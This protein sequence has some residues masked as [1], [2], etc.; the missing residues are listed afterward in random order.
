MLS[1]LSEI[2]GRRA[3]L[4]NAG[5][6]ARPPRSS[7]SNQ[8]TRGTRYTREGKRPA[9][10]KQEKPPEERH[11]TERKRAKSN[12]SET[13]QTSNKAVSK[14]KEP[15]SSEYSSRNWKGVSKDARTR[16]TLPENLTERRRPT[17]EQKANNDKQA[18]GAGSERERWWRTLDDPQVGATSV[19]AGERTQGKSVVV[20][21]WPFFCNSWRL[22][23]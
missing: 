20:W 13:W 16:N 4:D 6:M 23:P 19:R 3:K 12:L 18:N 8:R 9:H 7:R 17:A 11:D 2:N 15:H 21:E 10:A 22:W 1:Q 14:T 5:T